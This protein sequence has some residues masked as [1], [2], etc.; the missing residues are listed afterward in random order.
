MRFIN[1]E[2]TSR[3]ILTLLRGW[4]EWGI[5]LWISIKMECFAIKYTLKFMLG[6]ILVRCGD[7]KNT[8]RNFCVLVY[9][10][11][12]KNV[13]K[14]E[15]T[16][17][18]RIYP[19]AKPQWDWPSGETPWEMNIEDQGGNSIRSLAARVDTETMETCWLSFSC[20]A[21]AWVF[22]ELRATSLTVTTM[23]WNLLY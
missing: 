23:D 15:G 13:E 11:K 21:S 7:L 3:E 18:F 12:K 16:I 8:R 1:T 19:T 6:K 10:I 9:H 22:I 2:W 20:L 5:G 17:C 4:K 14:W